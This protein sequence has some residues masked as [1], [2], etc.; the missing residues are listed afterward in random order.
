MARQHQ[1]YIQDLRDKDIE[2]VFVHLNANQLSDPA[3]VPNPRQLAQDAYDWVV[4]EFERR[5]TLLV[6]EL[7]E[8]PYQ[9]LTALPVAT[10]QPKRYPHPGP[11]SVAGTVSV[12][13]GDRHCRLSE[14]CSALT[15]GFRCS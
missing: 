7:R 13:Y 11:D 12:A 8:L 15:C 2:V 6:D 10:I 14:S 9:Q 3:A 4:A 5:R 1:K